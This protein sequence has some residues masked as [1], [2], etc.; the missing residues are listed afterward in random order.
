MGCGLGGSKMW[1]RVTADTKSMKGVVV[2]L[3]GGCDDGAWWQV[4][5]CVWGVVNLGVCVKV[6]SCRIKGTKETSMKNEDE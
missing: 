2:G 4:W 5:G 6:A 3:D 1:N